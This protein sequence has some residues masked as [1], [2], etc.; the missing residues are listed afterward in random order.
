MMG[1]YVKI[2]CPNEPFNESRDDTNVDHS[3][4]VCGA[5]IG[6]IPEDYLKSRNSINL[7]FH[8]PFCKMFWEV[9]IPGNGELPSFKHVDEIISFTELLDVYPNVNVEG[10]KLRKKR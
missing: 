3:E 1:N 7:L 2:C 4:I 8:C 10:R 5:I 9:V 6:G